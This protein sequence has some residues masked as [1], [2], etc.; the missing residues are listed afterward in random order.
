MNIPVRDKQDVEVGLRPEDRWLPVLMVLFVGSGAAAL[1]YEVV[2]LQL[3]QLVIGAT[4]VSLAVLLGTFMG[5]M[6]VGSVLLPRLIPASW[7]PLRVYSALEAAIALCGFLLMRWLPQ[8]D[9][10]YSAYAGGGTTGMWLRAYLASIVLLPPTIC[11]GATLPAVARF[12][13]RSPRGVAWLGYFYGGNI[14]GAVVGCLATGFYLLRYYDMPTATYVAILLNL[15][16]ALIGWALAIWA[17]PTPSDIRAGSTLQAE[18]VGRILDSGTDSTPEQHVYQSPVV[19]HAMHFPR[20][21]IYLTIGLSGF[22]ALG[23]EVTWTRLLSLILGGTV[24][25]FAIILAVFLVGL[26]L[27]SSAG[28]YLSRCSRPAVRLGICQGMLAAATAWAAYQLTQSVPFWPIDLSL[29]R[30]PWDVL[31]LDVLRSAWAILPAACLWGASFPLALAAAMPQRGTDM[32]Q[33][34]SVVDTRRVVGAVYAANTLGAIAGS[35]LFSLAFIAWW[36]SHRA[37]QLLVAIPLLASA[38]V[39]VPC[40]FGSWVEQWAGLRGVRCPA[41]LFTAPVVTM[42]VFGAYGMGFWLVAHVPPTPGELI[43]YG[44]F[45]PRDYGWGKVIYAREGQNASVA[46]TQL[47]SGVRNFH[48]SGKIEASSESLDMRLQRMLGYLPALLHPEPRSVLIVGCGAGVTAGTF[49][50]CPTIER[51]VICEIEPLV[52]DAVARYFSEENYGVIQ[53]ARVEVVYDDARH[54]ILTCRE[55]FDIIT[56]DPIHPWVKG[57]ASLFTE[58]YFHLCRQRLKPGGF[59]SQW[60]PLYESDLDTVKTEIATFFSVFPEGTLW[61]N[62]DRGSG[63]DT[64]LL[65]HDGPLKIDVAF[66]EERLLQPDYQEVAQSMC[67]VGFNSITD[68]LATY[69]ASA[70]DLRPWLK[71]ATINRDINLKLQYMAGLSSS[72]HREGV[73]FSE[74]HQYCRIRD[75]LFL[76]PQ[77]RLHE[78]W[79]RIFRKSSSNSHTSHLTTPGESVATES[80]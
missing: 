66:L 31:Q 2:W 59:M 6:C 42:A 24:Y 28:A 74:I 62:D 60:V 46:V 50:L 47:E 26:G 23:A 76:L 44:R 57:S 65:G 22:A 19:G 9:V 72:Y 15:S 30:S 27:G 20:W 70:Q 4:A 38:L 52:P 7:H 25:S 41:A 51:I 12:V 69:A 78:L 48:I 55:Q 54:F 29:T 68:L 32:L 73:I 61:S 43:A 3:L 34:S 79:R 39:M 13:E 14:A 5:G 67:Q 36:G 1:I 49:V 77:D 45:L 58:E 35:V 56:S 11:M 17:V 63:Y 21:L 64:V 80:R 40:L 18:P 16:V 10:W 33:R 75:D 53:D 37:Q 71:D 8:L